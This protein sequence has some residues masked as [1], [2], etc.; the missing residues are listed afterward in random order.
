ME[1]VQKNICSG[2]RRGMS[3][4]SRASHGPGAVHRHFQKNNNLV[5]D[6][7]IQIMMDLFENVWGSRSELVV[8]HCVDI[9][10]PVCFPWL[11]RSCSS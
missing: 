10:L 2:I 1:E 7:A 3:R 9:T 11:K 5:W 8:D 6:E 4:E